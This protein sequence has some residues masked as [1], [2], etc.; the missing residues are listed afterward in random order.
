M[1]KTYIA[2]TAEIDD[3]DDAV[4]GILAQLDLENGLRANSIGIIACHYDFVFSGV[5][6]A[7]S[8]ALPFDVVGA[9]TMIQAVPQKVGFG[10]LSLMVLT[11]D[12]VTFTT[13]LTP[14]LGSNPCDNIE[15]TYREAAGRTAE[16]PALIMPFAPVVLGHI[17][18]DYI[19]TLTQISGGVPC[20]G[21]LG[22]DDTDALGNSFLIFNGAHYSD[23]MGLVLVC[24]PTP[25]MLFSATISPQKISQLN[26]L[27]TKSEGCVLIEVNGRPVGDFFESL[28]IPSSAQSQY[29]MVTLPFMLNFN[30]GTPPV[31]RIFMARTPEGYAVSTGL[32]PERATINVGVFDKEDVLC[33]AG[34]VTKAILE[35]AKSHSCLLIYSCMARSFS[36]AGD[37]LSEGALV[38]EMVGDRL[39]FMMA[40][41][42]G[43]ICPSLTDDNRLINRY[44]SNTFIACLL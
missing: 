20:F 6:K 35:Q 29:A 38:R 14:P 31:S 32:I 5:V 1:I 13:A 27:V 25:P 34:K 2:Y 7:L 39:P 30:D 43:E 3:V 24:S 44:H 28:G 9:V 4:A 16:T 8:E 10:F 41:S 36:L 26:S 22:V 23:R 42:G 21:T 12:T 11:S 37:S 19:N 18:D 33:T 17:G 15:S 40:Y